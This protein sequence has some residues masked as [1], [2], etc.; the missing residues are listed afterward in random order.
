[1]GNRFLDRV[2]D[3]AAVRAWAEMTQRE[4]GNSLAEG[5]WN[6]EVR[7]LFYSNYGDFPYLLY[8]KVNKRLF[9]ALAQF[10]NPAY[11]C[12]TF[13]KV[14]LVPTIEEYMALLQCSRIQVDRIY[15]KMVNVPTFLR[16]LMN[17]TG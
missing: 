17:I 13:G 12:F 3:N 1:M 6:N 4:K 16:K 15:S 10:W 14:D 5:Y 7:Q 8:M 11:S 2:E 9:R